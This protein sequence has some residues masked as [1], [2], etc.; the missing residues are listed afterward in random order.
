MRYDFLCRRSG[1]LQSLQHDFPS[2]RQAPKNSSPWRWI[3]DWFRFVFC[4]QNESDSATAQHLTAKCALLMASNYVFRCCAKVLVLEVRRGC[5]SVI[6]DINIDAVS[7]NISFV[8]SR[9]IVSY[10]NWVWSYYKV[11]KDMRRLTTGIR[12]E[13]CVVRRCRLCANVRVYLHNPR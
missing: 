3:N 4:Q 8:S 1:G 11:T 2:D 12:S 6:C 9:K 5:R 7:W 13:K 10:W